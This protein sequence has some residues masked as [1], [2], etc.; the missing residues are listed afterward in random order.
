M[1]YNELFDLITDDLFEIVRVGSDI[2]VDSIIDETDVVKA[3][4]HCCMNGPVGVN[5]PTTFPGIVGEKKVKDLF[6]SRVSNRTWRK[7]CERFAETLRRKFS[8]EQR[9]KCQTVRLYGD[10]WPSYEESN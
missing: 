7:L 9:L 1:D 8:E 2:E 4:M 3:A 6:S 10:F 5:K